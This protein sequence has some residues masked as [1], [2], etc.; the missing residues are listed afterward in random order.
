MLDQSHVVNLTLT[1]SM[2]IVTRQVALYELE[3]VFSATEPDVRPLIY[4]SS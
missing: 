4:S 3:L 2:L 1:Y